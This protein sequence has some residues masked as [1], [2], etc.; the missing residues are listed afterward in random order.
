MAA[1]KLKDARPCR[2]RLDPA[3]PHRFGGK[4]AHRG[5]TPP[6]TDTPLHL[7]LLL[8]LSDANCPIESDGS[9]Q[10][11]PLYYPLKYGFG[12]PSVQYA[13]LSEDEISILY[14][15]EQEA[16]PA[17]HQYVQVPELPASSAE[18]VPLSYE[19]A[20][21][22]AF[23][24]GYFQPNAADRAILE[25]L[26]REHALILIGGS[27]RLPVNAGDV[28]CRNRQCKFCD[29]HVSVDVLAKIPPIP[30]NGESDFWHEFEGACMEFYFALC[31]H[32]RTVIAF[33]VAE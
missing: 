3:G 29:Q 28:I 6:H 18:I 1:F 26:S 23:A 4:P 25:G 17:E 8:D 16:D 14:L 11:L 30:I 7:F 22:L 20:R 33:N 32:C 19:E 27:D 2:L 24:G 13:V 12:G 9:V 15:S 5:V 21:I 10:H 31:P